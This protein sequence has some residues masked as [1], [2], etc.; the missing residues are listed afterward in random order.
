MQRIRPFPACNTGQSGVISFNYK[1]G[2]TNL[3]ALGRALGVAVCM[4]TSSLAVIVHT[5]T[6]I[7]NMAKHIHTIPYFKTR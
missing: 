1:I 6:L 4:K 2:R 3:V 7:E 5:S